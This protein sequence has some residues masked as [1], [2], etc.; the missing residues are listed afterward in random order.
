MRIFHRPTS[1]KSMKIVFTDEDRELDLDHGVHG[2]LFHCLRAPFT[3]SAARQLI[4]TRGRA[5]ALKEVSSFVAICP[6]RE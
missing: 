2:H 3:G 1:K 4:T 5:G 6:S